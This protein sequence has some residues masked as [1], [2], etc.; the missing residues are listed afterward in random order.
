M[1]DR[2][3][4]KKHMIISMC[5][6]L[7]TEAFRNNQ[8]NLITPLGIISGKPF[9]YSDKDKPQSAEDILS[10][11]E[12]EIANEYKKTYSIEPPLPGND[13]FVVLENVTI[14]RNG[15]NISTKMSLLT[16][17]FDQII[18]VSLGAFSA[19]K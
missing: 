14:R 11:V 15:S 4:L 19:N 7:D 1:P 8:V 12:E 10:K 13:G 6:L 2:P 3:S 9:K 5:D 16:I 18:G 17:F